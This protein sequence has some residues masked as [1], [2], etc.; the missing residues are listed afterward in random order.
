MLEPSATWISTYP[1]AAIGVL[2]MRDV[3]N[4][5][6]CG[7]LDERKR[8]L[9]Q[10]LR[11]AYGDEDREAIKRLPVIE[12]YREYYKQFKKT[13][14]VRHQLES[15]ALKGEDIPR[16]AALVEAMFMAELEHLLLTAGHDLDHVVP[17]VTVSVAEGTE[18]YTRINGREQTLKAGDMYI[19]DSQG[20]MSSII[21]GPDRRTMIRPET[22]KVLFT[23]YA[24]AGIGETLVEQH[25]GAIRD[26]VRLIAPDAS[27]DT[28]QIITAKGH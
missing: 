13:Y 16:T 11:E 21:Y 3:E 20:V 4:P 19:A 27:V 2:V 5:E 24:P 12:A 22:R 8:A 9:E 10:R 23:T 17:P 7:P 18:T 1:N 6:S 28:L 15:V 14:H 26:Y 25:L